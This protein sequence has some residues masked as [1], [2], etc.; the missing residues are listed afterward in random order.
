M[1]SAQDNAFTISNIFQGREYGRF[2]R[3]SGVVWTTSGSRLPTIG[4]K[5]KDTKEHVWKVEDLPE[6]QP[7]EKTRI[8][9]SDGIAELVLTV[10]FSIIGILFCLGSFPFAMII[11][12]DQMQVTH[13]FSTEFL[14]ALVPVIAVTAAFGIVSAVAK[15]KDCRWT[16]MVCTLHVLQKLVSMGLSVYMLTRPFIFSAEFSAS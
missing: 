9:L 7:N 5:S 10:V 12:H 13:I 6:L 4:K 14:A 16:P 2:R 3:V 15:I 8:P 11:I 1:S